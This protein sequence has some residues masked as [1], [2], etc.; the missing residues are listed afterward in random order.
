VAEGQQQQ[1][2]QQQSLPVCIGKFLPSIRLAGAAATRK[3]DMLL[4]WHRKV[5]QWYCMCWHV[6]YTKRNTAHVQI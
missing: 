5:A 1:Q 4:L 2:Q 6:I 3:Y